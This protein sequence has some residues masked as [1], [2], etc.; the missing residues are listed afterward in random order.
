MTTP[1][2]WPVS[3][4]WLACAL[5]SAVIVVGLAT[6][7][8]RAR[9]TAQD[10]APL[11]CA[12][13]VTQRAAQALLDADP[14]YSPNV[15]PDADGLACEDLPATLLITTVV[16]RSG[17]RAT[18]ATTPRT[19]AS[20]IANETAVP[21]AT[22]RA[23]DTPMPTSTAT[24]EPTLTATVTPEPTSTPEPTATA[25]ATRAPTAT[26][27]LEST[28]TATP[29]P[30]A[31][32]SATPTMDPTPDE[33]PTIVTRPRPSATPTDPQPIIAPDPGA[34]DAPLYGRFGGP[35]QGFENVY[36]EPIDAEPAEYPGGANYAVTG[37]EA[38]T[39]AYH[40]DYVNALTITLPAPVD[41]EGAEALTERFL[42]ADTRLGGVRV[43]SDTGDIVVSATSAALVDRFG[44]ATYDLYGAVGDRGTFHYR[45]RGGDDGT[46]TVVEI[47]LGTG[48]DAAPD[49]DVTASPDATA[50]ADSGTDDERVA[51]DDDA[52][53]AAVRADY[54]VLIASLGAFAALIGAPPADP[55]ETY[56]AAIIAE[57]AVWQS[58][59]AAA[60]ELIPPATHADLHEE[61]LAFTGILDTAAADIITGIETD[62]PAAVESGI[63][64]VVDATA[65]I[66]SIDEALASAE[67]PRG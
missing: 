8:A 60:A 54:E 53:L 31:T 3:P 62:D 52:Y 36:G 1:P 32:A 66:A 30:T 41:R 14:S 15:D 67:G 19:A 21:S 33:G 11:S 61:Y 45:L 25:T 50:A 51:S 55:T 65:L 6:V 17:P 24:P 27:T 9:A 37:F 34:P 49:P 7:T 26:A 12:D 42:P 59:A 13:F 18:D 47:R 29:E 56:L 35:R 58:T 23:T 2:R 43:E 20:P 5:I 10:I 57:C 16:V 39:A 63:A 48:R 40:H 46:F 64:Q 22:A 28:A 4:G 44:A 38:I